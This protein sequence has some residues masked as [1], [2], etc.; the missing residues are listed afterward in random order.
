MVRKQRR[1]LNKRNVR[2]MLSLCHFSFK[3]RLLEVAKSRG[4]KVVICDESYTT[5]TCGNC[6]FIHDHIGCDRTF[7]CPSCSI[8]IDRDFNAARNIYMKH[9]CK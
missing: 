2:L 1:K 9:T 5:K 7:V 6:G 4:C 8:V 3:C